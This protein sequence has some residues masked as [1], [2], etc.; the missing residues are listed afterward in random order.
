MLIALKV[1]KGC[2]VYSD[3]ILKYDMQESSNACVRARRFDDKYSDRH[4]WNRWVNSFVSF[5]FSQLGG[6][7]LGGLF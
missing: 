6:S 1:T 5:F 2:K 4:K 3:D 7:W